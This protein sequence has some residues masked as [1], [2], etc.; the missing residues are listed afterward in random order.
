MYLTMDDLM[1][2]FQVT[3]PTIYKWINDKKL[4]KVKLGKRAVR[5]RVVDVD[6]FEAKLLCQKKN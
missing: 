4:R 5:F 1:K 2:K 6:A 3:R